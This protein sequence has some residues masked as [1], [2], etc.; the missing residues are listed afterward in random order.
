MF[1][2]CKQKTADDMRISDWSSDVCSS[3]LEYC[4]RA[5]TRTYQWENI[6]GHG[7]LY[8]GPLFIHQ[9]SHAWIDFRGIHDRFMREKGCDYFENSRRA[10]HVQ[11]AYACINPRGHA[12]YDADC[13][14]FS[15]CEGPTAEVQAV[16]ADPRHPFG[17]AAGGVPSGPD[18]GTLSPPA[19]LAWLSLPTDPAP[20][21]P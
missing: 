16:D 20:D 12:G 13:W 17:S 18:A 8:A 2:V 11:R 7:F 19:V 21:P 10:V 9:C 3:D 6:Y 15:A 1:F 4:Y 14:G 5:C